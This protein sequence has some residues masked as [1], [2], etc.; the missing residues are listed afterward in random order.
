MLESSVSL[1]WSFYFEVITKLWVKE[2]LGDWRFLLDPEGFGQWCR[3][4]VRDFVQ[5]RSH[6]VLTT[7]DLATLLH[8]CGVD[9]IRLF[10]WTLLNWSLNSQSLKITLNLSFLP[11]TKFNKI[12]DERKKVL[13]VLVGTV[14]AK[15]VSSR[16]FLVRMVPGLCWASGWLVSSGGQVETGLS[17]MAC[18]RS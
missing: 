5:I 13:Y 9:C 15:M 1:S 17:R 10:C 4:S 12:R 7:V 14:Q 3:L 16:L 2:V 18:F 11:T 6:C 8:V